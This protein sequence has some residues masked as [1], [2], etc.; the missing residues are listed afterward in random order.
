METASLDNGFTLRDAVHL[1]VRGD[2]PV[3]NVSC[4]SFCG[5]SPRAWR[6]Q[7][8]RSVKA[9]PDRFI[10]TCVETATTPLSKTDR[11]AVHLHVRG[12]S[13]G[14]TPAEARGVGSS[15]RAWRQLC[16]VKV[17]G[18]R[19]RFISTCVETAPAARDEPHASQ[20]HLHVRGDSESNSIASS[21]EPGSSPRAWRQP[22]RYDVVNRR[23]RFIST[24]VETA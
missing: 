6:Q 10:S 18:E 7:G 5:S 9:K 2:S 22:V 13:S 3:D 20:V 16:G 14:E 4:F 12:D 24:C 11:P 17:V 19:L 23:R 15:P 21:I 1:H 8:N